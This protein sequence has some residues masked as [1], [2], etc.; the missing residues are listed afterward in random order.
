[1]VFPAGTQIF[2]LSKIAPLR[3]ETF[4]LL[5]S[6]STGNSHLKLFGHNSLAILAKEKAQFFLSLTNILNQTPVCALEYVPSFAFL[7]FN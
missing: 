4:S 1:M 3:A 7:V 2:S 5:K 6:F